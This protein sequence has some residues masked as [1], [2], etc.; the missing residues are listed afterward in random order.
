MITTDNNDSKHPQNHSNSECLAECHN[1][2]CNIL[3]VDKNELTFYP[4]GTDDNPIAV[5]LCI[6]THLCH[7]NASLINT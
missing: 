3:N 6:V 1:S 2:Q 4:D 5:D 7:P